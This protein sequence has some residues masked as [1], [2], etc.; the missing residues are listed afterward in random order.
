MGSEFKDYFSEGSDA[1][2]N[3]RPDYPAALFRYLSFLCQSHD[4]AWDCATGNG[5]TAMALSHYY[6]EVIGTDASQNQISHAPQKAGVIYRVEKAEQSSLEDNSIDLVTVAQALHWFDINAFLSEINRVLKSKGVLAVWTYGLLDINQELNDEINTL[7]GPV[8]D[9]C[10]PP[11][12]RLVEE[13][14]RNIDFPFKEIQV[15]NFRM[16]T[17]WNLAQLVGYLGTWSAVKKYEAAK[18]VNPVEQRYE[19]LASLWGDPDNPLPMQWPL[20]TRVWVKP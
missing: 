10:W 3:F 18:G 13:G 11:E 16:E 19:K 9:A 20:T 2:R 7:Y 12:R 1:Y 4:R 17:E 5:Q 15:P 6:S 14:Y 8:L